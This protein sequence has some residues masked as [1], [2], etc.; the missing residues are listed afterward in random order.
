LAVSWGEYALIFLN[1]LSFLELSDHLVIMRLLKLEENDE[2]SLTEF[3]GDNIP[4]Y[5]ILSHT[6][7]LI[8]K[9]LPSKM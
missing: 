1:R 8:T 5:A 4:R 9:R 2:P 7:E 6:C 3:F